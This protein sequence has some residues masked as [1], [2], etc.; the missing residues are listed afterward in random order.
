MYTEFKDKVVLVTGGNSG[1]CKA[2]A[3]A[4]AKECANVIIIKL[5]H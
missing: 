1:I 2:M 4:F 3:L 5:N